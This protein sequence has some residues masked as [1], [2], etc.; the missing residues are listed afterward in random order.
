MLKHTSSAKNSKKVFKGILF[1]STVSDL[2]S[3]ASNPPHPLKTV[4]NYN[5]SQKNKSTLL[6]TNIWR[7]A[8]LFT[9][10]KFENYLF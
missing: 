5:K 9:Q 1:F 8:I 6:H 4:P 3:T 7:P 2:I 10:N